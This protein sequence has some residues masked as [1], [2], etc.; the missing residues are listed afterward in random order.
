MES[1]QER[2]ERERK[3]RELTYAQMNTFE[4]AKYRNLETEYEIEKQTGGPVH[5]DKDAWIKARMYGKR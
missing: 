4:K 3:A 1:Y 5:P 2:A